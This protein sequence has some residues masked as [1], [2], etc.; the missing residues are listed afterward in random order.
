MIYE[1]AKYGRSEKFTDV[2]VQ[3]VGREFFS[4]GPE[5]GKYTEGR[6]HLK[7]WTE[8]SDYSTDR[9]IGKDREELQE[10]DRYLN[11]ITTAFGSHFVKH[12]LSVVQLRRIAAI[13]G[14]EDETP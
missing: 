10:M 2:V 7:T 6:F 14:E 1:P 9:I 8:K 5:S 13:I 12:A 4:V 3:K 11:R